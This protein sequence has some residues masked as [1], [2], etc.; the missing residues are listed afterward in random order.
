MRKGYFRYNVSYIKKPN[1][2]SG[3]YNR[4]SQRKCRLYGQN[5]FEALVDKYQLIDPTKYTTKGVRL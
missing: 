3:Y 4:K 1:R 5:A 2:R